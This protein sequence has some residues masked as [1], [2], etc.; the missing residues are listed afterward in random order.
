MLPS[1]AQ[2][3]EVS[4]LNALRRDY[5]QFHLLHSFFTAQSTDASFLGMTKKEVLKDRRS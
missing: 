4:L 5:K 1:S 3:V 2:A